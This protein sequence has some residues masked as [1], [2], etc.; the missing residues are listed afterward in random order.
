MQ[1]AWMDNVVELAQDQPHRVCDGEDVT[2]QLMCAW[3][4]EETFTLP[5]V[6]PDGAGR[7]VPIIY[8]SWSYP[9]R[10]NVL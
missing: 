2:S 10:L 6:R 4:K 7:F 9:C 5:E 3:V 8:F 1:N